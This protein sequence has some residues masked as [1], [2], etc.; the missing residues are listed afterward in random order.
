MLIIP[1]SIA[2]SN[3]AEMASVAAITPQNTAPAITEVFV[4]ANI[5]ILLTVRPQRLC[6]TRFPPH[7]P[8]TATGEVCFVLCPLYASARR[9]RYECTHR[10]SVKYWRSGCDVFHPVAYVATPRQ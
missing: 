2:P 10:F 3:F 8:R 1:S 9:T 7:R 5:A 4:P 6:F